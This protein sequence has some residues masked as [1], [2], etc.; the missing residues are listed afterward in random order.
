MSPPSV[1]RDDVRAMIQRWIDAYPV[2]AFP[3]DGESR[4]CIAAAMGRHMGKCLL[5]ELR[6]A[7]L[8]AAKQEK[9]QD[10]ND[11]ARVV[12]HPSAEHGDLPRPATGTSERFSP[13]KNEY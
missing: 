1:L 11:H 2:D 4:D 9:E 8:E 10:E 7:C 5:E 13:D 12:S 3:P 6:L